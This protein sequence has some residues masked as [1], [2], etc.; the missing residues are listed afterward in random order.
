MFKSF[1]KILSITGAGGLALIP[2]IVWAQGF[3]GSVGKLSDF[4]NKGIGPDV[5][6]S[7]GSLVSIGMSLAGTIFLVLAVYAGIN[8]MIAA[9]NDE[10]AANSK[11]ILT[12]AVIGMLIVVLSYAITFF[13]TSKL[14]PP[15]G[16]TNGGG[17]QDCATLGGTCY[18]GNDTGLTTGKAGKGDSYNPDSGKYDNTVRIDECPINTVPAGT[19]GCDANLV[20]CVPFWK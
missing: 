7:M 10:Q 1:A 13:I 14:T 11:K 5:P 15:S 19:K 16:S 4:A 12:M 18:G 20:C 2:Q 8:W 17:E 9:G 6:T 3:T